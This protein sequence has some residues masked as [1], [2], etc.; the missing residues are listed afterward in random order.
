MILPNY[1]YSK[2]HGSLVNITNAIIVT[3][4][5]PEDWHTAAEMAKEHLWLDFF[6]H[7]LC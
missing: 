3:R 2:N 5:W 1:Y 6:K 7:L 4:K